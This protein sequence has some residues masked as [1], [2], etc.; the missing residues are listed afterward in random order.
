MMT[1][2]FY[3]E[4]PTFCQM[5]FHMSFGLPF[6]NITEEECFEIFTSVI[7]EHDEDIYLVEEEGVTLLV[8]RLSE[9][10]TNN[11][12]MIMVDKGLATMY[13]DGTEFVFG[14][15]DEGKDYAKSQLS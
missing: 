1:D 11:T 13:H 3:N 9:R 7:T 14:L 15:T 6:E 4:I 8:E 10:I 2:V 5:A 12:L